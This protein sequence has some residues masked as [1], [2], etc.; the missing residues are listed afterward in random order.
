MNLLP[1]ATISIH[2]DSGKRLHSKLENHSLSRQII[3]FYGP[4]SIAMFVYERVYNHIM[5]FHKARTRDMSEF[6]IPSGKQPHNYG[7]NHQTIHGK[8]QSINGYFP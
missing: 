4:S 8:T 7:L 2:I 1:M 6:E 3:F 5:I